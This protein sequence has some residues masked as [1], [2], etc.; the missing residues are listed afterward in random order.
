MEFGEGYILRYFP[1]HPIW[2]LVDDGR[3]MTITRWNDSAIMTVRW[4]KSITLSLHHTMELSTF[5]R[6]RFFARK[7]RQIW[8]FLRYTNLTKQYRFALT[9][10]WNQGYSIGPASGRLSVRI[11]AAT[12]LNRKI[13][14]VTA[15]PLNARQQVLVIRVLGDEHYIG[16][17]VSQLMCHAKNPHCTMA[18]SVEHKSKFSA[19]FQ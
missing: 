9:I 8:T 11:P 13:Q 16:C 3:A 14:V 19:L 12:D 5:L 1:Q 6:I 4:L 7:W 2:V 15:P 17:P 10:N 18:M